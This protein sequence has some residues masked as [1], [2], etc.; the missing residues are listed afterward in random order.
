MHKNY[1]SEST[2]LFLQCVTLNSVP[3]RGSSPAMSIM[4]LLSA[5]AAT[6]P[7]VKGASSDNIRSALPLQ[8]VPK[9]GSAGYTWY[10]MSSLLTREAASHL[11]SSVTCW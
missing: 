10:W 9:I 5:F 11:L 3:M 8:D 6:M 1:H 4:Q 2:M 7:V